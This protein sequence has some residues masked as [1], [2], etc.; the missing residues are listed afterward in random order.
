LLHPKEIVAV[1]VLRGGCDGR[2][3]EVIA[4]ASQLYAVRQVKRRV[5]VSEPMWAR[6]L[7][8]M[9]GRSVGGCNLLPNKSKKA[10]QHG[11]Q[12]CPGNTHRPVT[13]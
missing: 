5:R 8:P 6:L 2:M 1:N 11:T 4:N 3:P 12:T 13:V 10:L 9:C 7:E